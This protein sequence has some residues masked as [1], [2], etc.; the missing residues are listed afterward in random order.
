M[1]KI[2]FIFAFVAALLV[3]C[4]DD[5][6]HVPGLWTDG[7]IIETFPG[8]TVHIQGQVSNYIGINS[9]TLACEDWGITKVY[10]LSAHKPKVF[11]YDYALIVPEDASFDSELKVMVSDKE[12]SEN[13][14]TITLKYKADT[15]APSFTEAVP[16]QTSV[17]FN[18]TTKKADYHLDLT[19]TDDRSLKEL[20]ISIP[21]LNVSDT[22][23]LKGGSVRLDK[24]FEIASAGSFPMTLTLEDNGGNSQ[25][26]STELV[27]MP[28]E[29]ENP[30][31]DYAQMYVFNAEENASD[32]VYGYY[33][34]MD[35]KDAYQYSCKIYA[36][37]DGT[38]LLL[39][40]TQ[41]QSGDLFG[42]SPYVSSKLMNNN[43]YVVPIT[44]EKAGYYYIWVDIQNHRYVLTPYEVEPTI[45][46]GNLY[47]TGSGFA[48]M[49]DWA[50]SSTMKSA[51][52]SYRKQLDL[53]LASG[54]NEVSICFT[55]G[56]WSNVWRCGSNQWWWLD[57][58]G[59]GG[60]VGTF[61]PHGATKVTVTFDTAELWCTVKK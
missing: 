7:D 49:K 59:Y 40:P 31:Q 5:A 22:I 8:D 13:K 14:R 58:Q 36:P 18:T 3:S 16:E 52:S 44:V 2:Y 33:H 23:A 51:G 12:G 24:N 6:N 1:K 17:E 53:T 50:F 27:V 55:D 39:A 9:I 48:T 57:N 30:I 32:Y 19:A 56:S 29:E 34:Y 45:Y 38:K 4:S 35:R 11:N 15:Q 42:V 26:Y 61:N 54:V 37:K 21:A 46:T 10:D 47:V 43:G 25:T 20:V 28:K 60:T 41:S